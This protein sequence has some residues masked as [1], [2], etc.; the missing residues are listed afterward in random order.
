MAGK[1]RDILFSDHHISF[2]IIHLAKCIIDIIRLYLREY[3]YN[4]IMYNLSPAVKVQF[5]NG[6]LGMAT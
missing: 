2:Y 6:Y 3:H 4:I 5:I 1:K